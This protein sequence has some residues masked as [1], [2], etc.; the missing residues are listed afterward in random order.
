MIL[1]SYAEPCQELVYFK[2]NSS[3][4]VYLCAL[5]K[6]NHILTEPER[7]LLY[8]QILAGEENAGFTADRNDKVIEILA[9]FGSA[10]RA[11]Q[12]KEV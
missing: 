4:K 10:D 3:P 5:H 7:Y 6:S 12:S 11:L 8:L 2:I 1:A 9:E